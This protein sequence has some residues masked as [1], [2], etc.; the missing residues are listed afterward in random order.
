MTNTTGKRGTDTRDIQDSVSALTPAQRF[1]FDHAGFSVGHGETQEQGKIRG[2]IELARAVE[3]AEEHGWEFEWEQDVDG[4]SGCDCRS[5]DCA[6]SAGTDHETL[7][8]ILRDSEPSCHDSYG[9]ARGGAVLASLGG[10]CSPT[11]EY[12]RVVEAELASE[13]L[14]AIETEEKNA[15]EC[16]A[17]LGEV[18]NG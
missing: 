15:R 9:R 18:S 1:F 13:A 8:C 3:Y 14:H 17:M 11:R 7:C 4:C 12:G 2:A 16:A 6:C 10:I 5:E